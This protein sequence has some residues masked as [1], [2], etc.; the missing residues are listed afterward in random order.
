VRQAQRQ[1]QRP[2]HE[3]LGQQPSGRLTSAG[4]NLQHMGA[5]S[6]STHLGEQL[7]DPL[8]VRRPSNPVVV[9]TMVEGKPARRLLVIHALSLSEEPG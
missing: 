5:F 7:V 6:Q 8:R 4:T 9:G 2:R 1:V 3:R